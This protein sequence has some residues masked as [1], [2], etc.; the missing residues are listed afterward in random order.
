M[1]YLVCYSTPDILD[2]A[3][4]ELSIL[5]NSILELSCHLKSAFTLS[6]SNGVLAAAKTEIK[7]LAAELASVNTE[8]IKESVAIAEIQSFVS[9]LEDVRTRQQK[10]VSTSD[11]TADIFKIEVSISYEST[12]SFI[13]NYISDLHDCPSLHGHL[14]A[15]LCVK[16]HSIRLE[17]LVY[18]AIASEL[19][20]CFRS[21]TLS[22]YSLTMPDSDRA[23]RR[24]L[25]AENYQSF[26][27]STGS[28]DFSQWS[29]ETVGRLRSIFM[30][31]PLEIQFGT[32]QFTAILSHIWTLHLMV[33]TFYA[34]PEIISFESGD[35][36]DGSDE[37]FHVVS[38][39]GP[40]VS[41]CVW[42]GFSLGDGIEYTPCKIVAS[43]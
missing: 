5:E 8:L 17:H 41:L 22:P 27:K 1:L 29:A 3:C 36:T 9:R 15:K 40:V 20:A 34:A 21:A 10:L 13:A 31:S 4:L 37:F 42:P 18:A 23:Q 11:I 32:P 6:G 39:A 35:S 30:S 2:E 19:F 43:E 24:K 28:A 25:A 26:I 38:G 14:S 33:P 12:I 16:Q 7:V